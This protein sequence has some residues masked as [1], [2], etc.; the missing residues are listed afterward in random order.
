MA[1]ASPPQAL[2]GTVARPR[3]RG[4]LARRDQRHAAG[5]EAPV[6]VTRGRGEAEREKDENR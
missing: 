3:L 1:I 2:N 6:D 5:P 4:R